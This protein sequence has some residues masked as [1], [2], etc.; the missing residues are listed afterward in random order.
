MTTL[1]IAA[2]G[3]SVLGAAVTA[4]L[5]VA[6]FTPMAGAAP[7][8]GGN[9][10]DGSDPIHAEVMHQRFVTTVEL[11]AGVVTIRP[12]PARLRPKTSE[13]K[14]ATQI[15]AT[16]QIMGYRPQALGFGIV[17]I[18]GHAAGVPSVRDLPAWVGLASVAQVAFNCPM[19]R[20]SPARPVRPLPTPGEAAVVLGDSVGGPAVVYR[21]RSAPCGSVV[22]A[23]LTNALEAFSVPWSALGPVESE[24]LTVRVAVPACGG[25]AGIATGGS[26]TAMTVTVYALVPESPVATS[27]APGRQV[28]RTVAMGPGNA[29]GAPP[30]L[31]SPTTVILHGKT[32]PTRVVGTRA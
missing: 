10:T 4:F 19:M 14:A 13:K 31:V 23:S 1:E 30:P 26:A 21:A 29:P 28:T 25:I 32:G 6:G 20:T 8:T 27:C 9:P 7:H 11:D 3:R 17:T 12:A 22:P 18:H 5:L 16:S 2:T 24:I 15:W